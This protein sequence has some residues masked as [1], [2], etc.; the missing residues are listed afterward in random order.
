MQ[1]RH[2]NFL[3]LVSTGLSNNAVSPAALQVC[4][5]VLGGDRERELVGV[6]QEYPGG[7]GG[8]GGGGGLW[9]Y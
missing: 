5:P 3:Q 4:G 7:G 8:G 6:G 1:L 9:T 2:A